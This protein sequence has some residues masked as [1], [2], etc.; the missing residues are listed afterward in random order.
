M[1]SRPKIQDVHD[2]NV[3]FYFVNHE[4]QDSQIN[5]QYIGKKRITS[6]DIFNYIK[7]IVNNEHVDIAMVVYQTIGAD[8]EF[9]SRGRGAGGM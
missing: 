6:I 9:F 8:P 1:K 3:Y 4:Q 2:T 5:D 7:K